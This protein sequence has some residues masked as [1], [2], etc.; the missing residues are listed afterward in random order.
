MLRKRHILAILVICSSIGTVSVFAVEKG[1]VHGQ[2]DNNP[3]EWIMKLISWWE[4][5][6]IS[7]DEY[8]NAIDY[9]T[10]SGI[11]QI[12]QTAQGLPLDCSG[13]ARCISGSV[14]QIVDGDT[15]NVER[16]SIM[17][18]IRFALTS[19]PELN[20]FGGQEA[21]KFLEQIC[22]RGSQVLVDEDDGQTEGSYGRIVGVV[23]CNDMNLNQEILDADLG[24]ISVNFCLKSEFSS[25]SWAQKHG[26]PVKEY[27]PPEP[28]TQIPSCDPSYP[29]VCILPPP[30]YL[31]CNDIQYTNFEVIPPDPHGFDG[32]N[33]GIGCETSTSSLPSVQPITPEPNCDPAYPTVCI[34]SPPPDLNCGDITHRNFTVLP[35]DPH[36]FDGDGDGIGC[37]S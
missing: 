24:D 5:N 23:Y 22:P 19:T 34:P 8:H 1:V 11:I 25:Y 10:D 15:I 18:A 3:P 4:Q 27:T 33:D 20:E 32:D 13:N 31:N 16:A 17:Y 35:P 21:K 30:P 6:L 37:E 26:C 2:Q 14:T 9:L 7:N 36:R 12:N 29:T 28:K